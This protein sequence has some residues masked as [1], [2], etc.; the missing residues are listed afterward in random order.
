MKQKCSIPRSRLIVALALM[1]GGAS[2]AADRDPD[3][4]VIAATV[5]GW[6][7]AGAALEPYDPVLVNDQLVGTSGTIEVA[8]KD[9]QSPHLYLCAKPPCL[10]TI[11]DFR[12]AP[13]SLLTRLGRAFSELASHR[14]KMPVSAISRGG[15]HLRQAVLAWNDG[16]LDLKDAAGWIDP[17]VYSV[18]LR[19]IK[20]I[21]IAQ[22][23]LRGSVNW[24]PPMATL[25]SFP[26]LAA[27]IYELSMASS[28]GDS[29]GSVAVLVAGVADYPAERE[30]F[31]AA[32][33]SLPQ[34]LDPITRDAFLNALLF[35]AARVRK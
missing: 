28:E 6:T 15:E 25:A 17:G 34:G 13:D 29:L 19:P 9:G 14:D 27:G 2:V 1:A 18:S 24:D 11:P 5:H 26:S 12:P 16:R 21:D 33:T 10:I 31:D 3:G 7:R 4:W 35:D 8:L 23:R 20:T 32:V 30:S 22:E